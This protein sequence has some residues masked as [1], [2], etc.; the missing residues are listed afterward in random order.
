M[1]EWRI[2][3][4]AYYLLRLPTFRMTNDQDATDE[5]IIP[6]VSGWA[7]G[8]CWLMF[9]STVLNYMDRQTVSLLRRADLAGVR[10]HDRTAISAGSSRRFT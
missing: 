1:R 2:G 4:M 10:D 9:A 7:W 8:L 3:A 5:P 6:I